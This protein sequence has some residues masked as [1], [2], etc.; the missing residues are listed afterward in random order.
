MPTR[1][2]ASR[3]PAG[4]YVEQVGVQEWHLLVA[5]R[6]P[7]ARLGAVMSGR[8]R[9]AAEAHVAAWQTTVQHARREEIHGRAPRR[10]ARRGLL[11]GEVA[12]EM[13]S[14]GLLVGEVVGAVLEEMSNGGGGLG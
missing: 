10:G 14:G 6:F 12:G 3:P 9:K 4:D 2:R 11:V 1:H 13:S 7:S 8:M 5:A